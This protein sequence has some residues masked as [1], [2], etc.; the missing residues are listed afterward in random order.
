MLYE[1]ILYLCVNFLDS[2][3]DIVSDQRK[4]SETNNVLSKKLEGITNN[5]Q[6]KPY[7]DRCS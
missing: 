6:L 2:N 7:N 3:V 1:Y 5:L 4:I